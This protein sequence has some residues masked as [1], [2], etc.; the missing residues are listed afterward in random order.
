MCGLNALVIQNNNGFNNPQL[1]AAMGNMWLT[2]L[3][4]NDS[5]G[6]VGVNNKG[7]AAWV[8]DI[9]PPSTL[10]SSDVWKE[11]Q[12]NLYSEGQLVFG[13]GRAATRGDITIE[14]AHPFAREKVNKK[15]KVI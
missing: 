8:K 15:E 7:M 10:F 13:H 1:T 14:N 12:K 3:R 11:F 4:G 6:A 9:G 5:T 2:Q